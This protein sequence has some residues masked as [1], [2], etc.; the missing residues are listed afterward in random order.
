VADVLALEGSDHTTAI[1]NGCPEELFVALW[2]AGHQPGCLRL[3]KGAVDAFS[4]R[5]GVSGHCVRILPAVSVE[6]RGEQVVREALAPR[7]QVV[8]EE[9]LARGRAAFQP[10]DGLSYYSD[11]LAAA[12]QAYPRGPRVG[13]FGAPAAGT[14]CVEFDVSRAYTSFLAEIKHVPVFSVFDE[15]RPAD[16]AAIEALAFYLVRVAQLDG[17]LFPRHI[18]FVPGETV[19][20]AQRCN[21]AIEVIGVVRP[22]KFTETNGAEVLRALYDDSECSDK[23]RK[24]IANIAYGLSNKRTNRKQAGACFLDEAEARAHGGFLMKM[25]P[26]F[27]TLKQGAKDLSE[28]YLP[29]GRLVLDA[30][31]RRLHATVAALGGAAIAVKVDAVFVAEEHATSATAALRAAGF[32]FAA[33]HTGWDVVGKL[34]VTNKPAPEV[35][36][37]E[38]DLSSPQAV[39]PVPVPVCE[40]FKVDEEA[41]IAGDWSSVDVLMPTKPL[42]PAAA[43]VMGDW[44]DAEGMLEDFEAFSRVLLE[45]QQSQQ[46]QKAASPVRGPIAIKATIPGGGKTHLDKSWLERTGQKETSL[47]ATPFN[48]LVSKNVQEG[49]RSITVHEL[50]GR[51]AVESDDGVTTKKPYDLT[52]ITHVFFDEIYLNPINQLGWIHAFKKKH[53]A[54]MTF[55][56]AGDP[57]QNTPVCQTLAVDSDAWYEMA[58]A[59][60]FPRCIL[61]EVSKRVRDPADRQRMTNLCTELRE[62][63][64]PVVDILRDAGLRTVAFE[65]LTKEEAH[66]PHVSAMRATMARVDHWAHAARGESDEY[67]VG[68]ELLGVDGVR[69]RGGRICSN[70]TYEVLEV[71]A[72][73]LTL[74]APDG[75]RR[76]VT[77]ATARRYLKRPYCRTGHSTQG[78]TLGDKIYI[79]DWQSMMATH[80][81]VRTAVSRCST[82]D[83]VLVTGSNGVRNNWHGSELRIKAHQAA[84]LDKGYVWDPAA[85]VTAKW[86]GEALRQQRYSCAACYEPLDTDWS[87]DRIANELPHIRGNCAISCRRCQNASAHRE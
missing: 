31:R 7:T 20:Y 41:T 53:G 23:A 14:P 61:L 48:A 29:V 13:S 86:V 16:G 6:Q 82:L 19:Q 17:V 64:R 51:L 9:H 38:L 73:G 52:G 27:V 76:V 65:D 34:R 32:Q 54:T 49:W 75:S 74:T 66:Y 69:C 81:W 25:G 57:G 45:E 2:E 46:E 87:I 79:H 42:S 83:I 39:R 63:V 58:L 80:R 11:S 60:M 43:F 8:F 71:S 21:I 15:V 5:I 37:L 33:G 26:G 28:G 72:S 84:D 36:Q 24:D 12:F 78:L 18:D 70:E 30:M 67:L 10:I 59:S 22:V 77:T 44:T 50:V 62:E 47:V 1:T 56:E 55:S 40:V 85:Y 68:Q 3:D 4:V 35:K